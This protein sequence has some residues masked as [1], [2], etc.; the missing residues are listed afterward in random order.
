MTKLQHQEMEKL[1]DNINP[2]A[3][4]PRGFGLWSTKLQIVWLRAN[5]KKDK[6]K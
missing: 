1:I 6:K 3:K 4:I 2:R 5:Q